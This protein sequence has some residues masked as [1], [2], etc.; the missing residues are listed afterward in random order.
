VHISNGGGHELTLELLE[1][2]KAGGL[3]FGGFADDENGK[4]PKRWKTLEDA[5]GRLLFRWRKGCLEEN[6]FA[7]TPDAELEK[8]MADPLDERTGSRRQSLMLRLGIEAKTFAE[9]AA[10]AGEKLKLTM[11][12]AALGTVPTGC[13]EDKGTYKAHG[14][15]WFKSILGGRELADKVFSLGLWPALKP[16]LLPFCNGVRAALDLPEI[17]DLPA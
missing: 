15:I 16:Q 5:L 4:H 12:E 6:V 1:A 10:T 2:L 13:E 3:S 8:L 9:V 17:E 14:G 7:V 11:I